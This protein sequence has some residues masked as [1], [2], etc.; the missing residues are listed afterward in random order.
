MKVSL[1]D[2]VA[3]YRNLQEEIAQA[4]FLQS[5]TLI[6]GPNVGALEQAVG[7]HMD[8]KHALGVGS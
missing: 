5:G 7:G 2:L 4:I 1:I 6:L 3:Q 8:V